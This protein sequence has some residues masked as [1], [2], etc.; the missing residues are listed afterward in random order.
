MRALSHS[1]ALSPTLS[2]SSRGRDSSSRRSR[3]RGSRSRRYSAAVGVAWAA[4]PH[5][6]EPFL[7]GLSLS[8][9]LPCSPTFHSHSLSQAWRNLSAVWR[10]KQFGVARVA[11][12]TNNGKMANI[13]FGE[14]NNKMAHIDGWQWAKGRRRKK[15]GEKSKE[16]RKQSRQKRGQQRGAW[17]PFCLS[18]CQSHKCK[19]HSNEMWPK[20]RE[21]RRGGEKGGEQSMLRP[22]ANNF[23]E[24]FMQHCSVSETGRDREGVR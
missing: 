19:C 13:F 14:A 24:I 4:R 21:M 12:Q 17:S 23:S 20:E 5:Y 9:A 1:A 6:N 8:Q 18:I 10:A 7:R 22:L 16:S 2:S 3:G 15:V 11:R